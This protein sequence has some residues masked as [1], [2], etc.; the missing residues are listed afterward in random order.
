VDVYEPGPGGMQ[1]NDF[2]AG[3]DPSGL[4]WTKAV[5]SDSVNV[6]LDGD[7]GD[8]SDGHKSE[9]VE[10]EGSASMRVNN[11]DVLDFGDI[12]NALFG[13]RPPKPA[14]LSYEIRWS[15][16]KER[17]N[18]N[19]P[20]QG[21]RG[22]FVRNQAQMEWSAKEGDFTFESAPARSSSSLFAEVGSMRNGSFFR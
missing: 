9:D 1:I 20:A 7:F 16:F 12:G 2:N 10:G 3:I 8:E 14:T 13:G 22:T 18:I 19:N 11:V 15:G 21:F 4:F 17:V 5:P 6:E